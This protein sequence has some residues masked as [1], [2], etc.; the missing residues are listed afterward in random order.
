MIELTAADLYQI[1][2]C[3]LQYFLMKHSHKTAAKSNIERVREIVTA[4]INYYYQQLEAGQVLSF[5]ELQF[6]FL[7]I[8]NRNKDLT[9][10]V[11]IKTKIEGATRTQYKKTGLRF[12][13][14]FY[15]RQELHVD[16]IIARQ[17][18][19]RV[20]IVTGQFY[21]K[22]SIPYITETPNGKISIINYR[23]GTKKYDT[24]WQKTDL[25]I[26]L[27]AY[28]YQSI[29]KK[30]PDNIF[31]HQLYSDTYAYL[32]RGKTDFRRMIKIIKNVKQL[33]DTG[34]FF[35]NEGFLCSSCP[36]RSLCANWH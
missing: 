14:H 8:W 19:F 25:D 3:G 4:S 6:K 32:K 16:Q 7:S 23:M 26:T 33:I 18:G 29:F 28:A 36:V 15:R 35:P 30:Q 21:I 13:D 17:V 1:R 24:F 31:V 9:N 10:P 2:H 12:L 5:K 27:Q 22:G 20:P 34:N 11:T